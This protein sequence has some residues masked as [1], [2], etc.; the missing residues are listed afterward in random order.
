MRSLLDS[1]KAHALKL[2]KVVLMRDIEET[3]NFHMQASQLNILR[4]YNN[5]HLAHIELLCH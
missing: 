5:F 3:S 4:K 1:N 2:P